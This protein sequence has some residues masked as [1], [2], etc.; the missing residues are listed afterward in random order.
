MRLRWRPLTWWLLSVMFFVAAFYFWRLG[1]EWAKKKESG[2]RSQE[3][4]GKGNDKAPRTNDERKPKSEG[5]GAGIV[6]HGAVAGNLNVPPEV[7]AGTNGPA[8][9]SPL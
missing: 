6:T 1:D 9:E 7:A 3:S 8:K 4:G 2:V 5:R